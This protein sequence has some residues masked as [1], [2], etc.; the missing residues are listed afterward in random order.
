MTREKDLNEINL[1]LKVLKEFYSLTEA[2][3]ELQEGERQQIIR[4]FRIR[5]INFLLEKLKT[6]N[7]EHELYKDKY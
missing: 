6:V 1:I 7:R 5:I 4:D 3:P 2:T